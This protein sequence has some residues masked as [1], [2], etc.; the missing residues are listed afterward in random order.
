MKQLKFSGVLVLLFVSVLVR[1]QEL[2]VQL[3]INSNSFTLNDELFEV[4]P[5]IADVSEASDIFELTDTDGVIS[6]GELV[7][8]NTRADYGYNFGLTYDYGIN[9]RLGL[10]VAGLISKKGY[11]AD[12]DLLGSL[13]RGFVDIDLM[14]IDIPLQLKYNIDLA[15]DKKFFLSAGPYLS[16]GFSGKESMGVKILGL[17]GGLDSDL[18]WGGSTDLIERTD[19]GLVGGLGI[20]LGQVDLGLQYRFGLANL[21]PIDIEGAELRQQTLSVN[22]GFK[23]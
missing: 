17:G 23:F 1:G 20:D 22:A 14:Y 10:Q 6:I 13:V 8:L 7:N 5:L 2:G 9:D 12:V 3:G 16:Y 11:R 19:Y 4:I 21:N 15:N 18:I